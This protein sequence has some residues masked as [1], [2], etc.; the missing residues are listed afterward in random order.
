MSENL[1][2]KVSKN[3]KIVRD[4]GDPPQPSF[5]MGD[6][7]ICDLCKGIIERE[8]LSQCGL[9]GRWACRK[10][11]WSSESMICNSCGGI[12]KLYSQ[13]IELERTAKKSSEENVSEISESITEKV[14]K[15]MKRK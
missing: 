6:S 15:K 7:F 2:K 5:D 4:Q 10:N 8:G 11:C 1:Y 13:S 9:C 3:I 12:V 14:K